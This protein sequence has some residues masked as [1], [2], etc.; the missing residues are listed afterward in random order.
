METFRKTPW[1]AVFNLFSLLLLFLVILFSPDPLEA[2]PVKI[3]VGV[4]QNPPKVFI[5][6][7]GTPKGFFVDLIREIAKEHGWEVEFVPGKWSEGLDRLTK[8]KIDLMT[9]VAYS[10][11]QAGK[12]QYH[13]VPV[14]SDWFQVY[15]H[16]GAGIESVVDLENKR[17]A[18][19]AGSVQQD[20]FTRYMEDFG[21]SCEIIPFESYLESFK[22]LHAG[23]VDAAIVNRYYGIRFLSGYDIDETGIIFHPTRLHYAAS[24]FLKKEILNA[25]DASLQRMTENHES[26]YYT[27]LEKWFSEEKIS[28]SPSWMLPVLLALSLGALLMIIAMNILRLQVKKR[29]HHILKINETLKKEIAIRRESELK[30]RELFENSPMA[31]FIIDPGNGVIRKANLAARELLGYSEEELRGKSFNALFPDGLHGAKVAQ[32]LYEK[33]LKEEKIISGEV[34]MSRSDGETVWVTLS[35]AGISD[36]EGRLQEVRAMANDIS[37]RKI[38]EEQLVRTQ[39]M[40]ALGVLAGGIAHDFNNILTA[41]IGYTEVVMEKTKANP[42]IYDK[43]EEVYKAGMHARNLVK[44]ILTFSRQTK[45]EVQPVQVKNVVRE[46]LKLLKASLPRSVVIQADLKSMAFVLAEPTQ[47]H[48]IIMNLC[49]NGIQA[50]PGEKGRIMIL[51]EEMR[52]EEE[53]PFSLNGVLNAGPYI[54]LKVS[55]TGSGISPENMDKIFD[56][57]FTTKAP[58]KGTGM[59][60]SVVLNIVKKLQG[61]IEIRNGAAGG[62][63][64]SVYFPVYEAAEEKQGQEEE[65]M[66]R[67]KESILLVED[68]ESI[69]Q[70]VKQNLEEAG[71]Y[72]TAM[73]DGLEALDYL[74]VNRDSIE[75]VISN[76]TMPKISGLTLAVEIAGA[77]I[78]VPLLIITGHGGEI[79]E[80]IKNN[81]LIAEVI[82]K[83]FTRSE[84]FRIVR[85]V[86]DKG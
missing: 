2:K 40:E 6:E 65:D 34:S 66:I 9:D 83:P 47:I 46:A 39:K 1:L 80:Q 19:L 15:V 12:W 25:I 85:R 78:T 71:Y 69:I 32:N 48:Q 22:M 42:L 33:F 58:G 49:M 74:K 53:R 54:H 86:L 3:R 59:G 60:L 36:E 81:P 44:Q 16:K 8:G 77:G 82:H 52:F 64:F 18:V 72:V 23:K 5:D 21:F 26:P 17:I 11:E 57:F 27:G 79:L 51:L 56:P 43:L 28:G 73:R 7:K 67:G 76:L 31:Y 38:L 37:D 45:G 35:V 63:E 68:N 29:T 41:I 20:A 70:L 13:D 14:L 50:L 55:D 30:F 84:L 24:P 10:L 62:T 61:G 4:Y 75:L